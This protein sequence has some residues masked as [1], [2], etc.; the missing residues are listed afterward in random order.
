MHTRTYLGTVLP[1]CYTMGTPQTHFSV[2][3]ALR[4]N[5]QQLETPE[6]SWLWVSQQQL[7]FHSCCCPTPLN[8]SG[9]S[10]CHYS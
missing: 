9:T 3:R 2:G 7:L 5:L 10:R 6:T 8:G 4:S 1:S